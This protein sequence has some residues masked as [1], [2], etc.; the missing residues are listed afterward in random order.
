MKKNPDNI[1]QE[2]APE[3]KWVPLE[4]ALPQIC[5]WSGEPK[6]AHDGIRQEIL[7]TGKY[8]RDRIQFQD[9]NG[10]L[11]I[12]KSSLNDWIKEKR[13]ENMRYH[14]DS[15]KE[16]YPFFKSNLEFFMYNQ[17]EY[18]PASLAKALKTNFNIEIGRSTVGN[19]LTRDTYHVPVRDTFH[20]MAKQFGCSPE[21]LG[22]VDI[23]SLYE[24]ATLAQDYSVNEEDVKF[25]Y[26]L[27]RT[28]DS[29]KN[30]FFE[31]GLQEY[32]QFLN[33]SSSVQEFY[34]HLE[35]SMASF[36]N[37]DSQGVRCGY[38]N[39]ST[40]LFIEYD[41]FLLYGKDS[42][43]TQPIFEIFR[44]KKLP[45]LNQV[46]L[47]L[48][49]DG[50]YTEL[51]HYFL[52]RQLM[53]GLIDTIPTEDSEQQMV[54]GWTMMLALAS[55]QNPFAERFVNANRPFWSFLLEETT[56]S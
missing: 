22:E 56:K 55:I 46:L 4:K 43:I 36:W 31:N 47:L 20:A 49:K 38:I 14:F 2:K 17:G 51:V 44:E 13:E 50:K 18:T 41:S 39:W 40:L 24:K 33:S 35:K 9:K 8:D 15:M 53:F 29:Q 27:I 32:F 23:K 52:A 26:P 48:K 21:V 11:F 1:C 37:A 5:E 34:S 28:E 45:L 3:D 30:A 6:D 7:D 25:F 54:G 10:T 12:R 42:E 16:K 19:Y